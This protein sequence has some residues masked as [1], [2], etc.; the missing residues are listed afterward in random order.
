MVVNA[1]AQV[2]R[3]FL[4]S[5]AEKKAKALYLKDKTLTVACLSSVVAQE[6]QLHQK[7]VIN[8]VNKIMGEEIV[9]KLRFLS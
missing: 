3:G 2:V 1:F 4:S 6:L 9:E 5:A 8:Q 7:K